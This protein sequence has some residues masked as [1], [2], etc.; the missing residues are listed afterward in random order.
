MGTQLLKH[1]PKRFFISCIPKQ[2]AGSVFFP[3]GSFNIFSTVTSSP[4]SS[5]CPE[6][7]NFWVSLVTMNISEI[8]DNFRHLSTVSWKSDVLP[9]FK[10]CLGYCSRLKGQ[11]R[12]PEPP[13]RIMDLM[14]LPPFFHER[15]ADKRRFGCFVLAFIRVHLN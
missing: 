1:L 4:S 15:A 5:I 9:S 2:I 11:R 12:V 10:N 3:S 14:F 7:K 6:T 8:S 13:A